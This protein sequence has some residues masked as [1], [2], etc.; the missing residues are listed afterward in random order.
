MPYRGF[1]SR[2][3]YTLERPRIERYERWVATHFDETWLISEHDRSVLAK[4]CPDANIQ[5]VRNG[6]D[7]KS[8]YPTDKS[9]I[10]N[11]LILV[12][13]MGVFHNVDAAIFLARHIL[14]IVCAEIPDTHL[15]IVGTAPNAKV[16]ALVSIPN[17]EVTGYVPDLNEALNQ[18]AAFVAPL[19]F[20]AGVQNKVLEAMA[21]GCPVITTPLVNQGIGA[22]HGRE[23]LIAEGAQETANTIIHL[24]RDEK[25]RTE[26]GKSARIFVQKHYNWDLVGQR[27]AQISSYET[28]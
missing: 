16:R 5:V 28:R 17:V 23:L 20:A 15:Q 18:S 4:N 9:E 26:L 6:V 1:G 25:L 24:L 13:H 3:L 7:T 27:M 22:Q 21:A 14:P 12:G 11:R 8:L 2:L 10:S 19:R